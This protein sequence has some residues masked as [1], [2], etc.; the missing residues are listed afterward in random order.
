[1]GVGVPLGHEGGFASLIDLRTGDIVWVNHVPSGVGELRD[2]EDAR[3]T[4]EQ[5]FKDLPED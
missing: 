5:L 1:M 3:K 4:V 2:K